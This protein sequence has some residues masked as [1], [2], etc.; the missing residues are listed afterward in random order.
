MAVIAD[1]EVSYQKYCNSFSPPIFF[2]DRIWR[3]Q[4]GKK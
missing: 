2:T 1:K 3:E 4:M